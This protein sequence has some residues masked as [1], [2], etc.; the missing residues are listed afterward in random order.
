MDISLRY[1]LLVHY[2]YPARKVSSRI[3]LKIDIHV[4]HR[5]KNR[6]ARC[7]FKRCCDCFRKNRRVS[8]DDHW[9][10]WWWWSMCLKYWNIR[11][12]R[13]HCCW[14]VRNLTNF[15]C[16]DDQASKAREKKDTKRCFA[17]FFYSC[18]WYLSLRALWFQAMPYQVTICFLLR[19]DINLF[20]FF[21]F[22]IKS[23]QTKACKINQTNK[24]SFE[25]LPR[26]FDTAMTRTS[27][28]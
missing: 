7:T 1:L 3:K 26:L 10:W 21:V 14:I 19:V 6:S 4:M 13:C 23:L 25:N 9:W 12:Q 16:D 8:L 22:I 27:F 28:I 5:N 18:L 20:S 2:L 24:N 17:L 15:T 11:S